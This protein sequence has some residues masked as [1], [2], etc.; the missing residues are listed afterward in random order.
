ML[1]Y[2]LRQR[3]VLLSILLF[4]LSAHSHQGLARTVEEIVQAAQHKK[5]SRSIAISCYAV[6]LTQEKIICAVRANKSVTPASTLKLLT[7]GAALEVLGP[8]YRFETNLQYDGTI[9]EHGTLHGNVYIKGGGDPALGS[10]RFKQHYHDPYFIDAWVKALKAQGIRKVTGAVVGDAQ[11]YTDH[12]VPATWAI[13]DLGEHYGAMVSGLSIFD[14]TFTVKL[15]AGAKGQAGAVVATVP[16]VPAEVQIIHQV[17]GDDI[18]YASV[19][20]YGTPY[21][22]VRSIKGRIPCTPKTAHLVVTSPDPAYWAAYT[23]REAL[24]QQG[25][26]VQQPATTLR[27]SNL[28]A[29]ARHHVHTTHSPTVQ[30]IVQYVNID[31]VNSYAEHLLKHLGLAM[32]R[33]GNNTAGA[34]ALKKFWKQQGVDTTGMLLYDGSG[35]STYN[36]LTARQLVEALCHMRKSSNFKAFYDSLPISGKTGGY[37]APF[38]KK[39][40]LYGRLRIK[41][42]ALCV[43]KSFAGYGTNAG[44]DEIAFAVL[45]NH[46][47][48][49]HVRNQIIEEILTALVRQE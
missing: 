39:A 32:S 49:I 34:K 29:A 46:C 45:I 8:E 9:D 2:P 18:Q 19:Q 33:P 44:G 36:A 37:I 20:A 35:L 10:R 4:A 6:N 1:Y 24:Q 15:Q 38:L 7:T 40:P 17:Q 42:G 5:A 27:R 25:V 11:I 31:S 30:E 28:P 48:D 43:C 23:L 21:A 14:N 22:P 16:A 12:P 26:Q 3:I 47:A 13:G 41:P